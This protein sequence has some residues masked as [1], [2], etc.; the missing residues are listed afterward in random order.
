MN[1]ER[2]GKTRHATEENKLA[3]WRKATADGRSSDRMQA[4][5]RSEIKHGRRVGMFGDDVKRYPE[6]Q[7]VAGSPRIGE[8]WEEGIT[9]FAGAA[10]RFG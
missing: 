10:V 9:S 6:G 5:L 8:L 7:L 3:S 4:Q 2:M 1:A